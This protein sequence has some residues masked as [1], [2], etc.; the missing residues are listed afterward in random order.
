MAKL[1]KKDVLHVA[2]LA[3]II[4]T[5]SEITKFTTQLSAVLDYMNELNEVDT[6]KTEP[7]SQTTGL[8]NV[9]RDDVVSSEQ[10]LTY[11]TPF[12][13]GAIL[14]DRTDK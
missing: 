6:S 3:K 12:S 1:T 2:D 7:T 10:S 4:L 11:D 5:D 8:V 14:K 9:Y 13:V